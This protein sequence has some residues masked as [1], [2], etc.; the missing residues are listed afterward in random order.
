VNGT[1]TCAKPKKHKRNH[2]IVTPAPPQSDL[3]RWP[4]CKFDIRKPISFLFLLICTPLFGQRYV[5][6]LR[7]GMTKAQAETTLHRKLL[8]A[9]PNG[10][11]MTTFA[12]ERRF[13]GVKWKMLLDFNKGALNQV[14]LSWRPGES[15][16][17]DERSSPNSCVAGEIQAAYGKPI[18]VDRA[19]QLTSEATFRKNG[20]EV[21]LLDYSNIGIVVIYDRPSVSGL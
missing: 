14:T 9:E 8:P 15:G 20:T 21:T 11:G 3:K 5:D 12:T 7:Y 4:P 19:G 6:D 17:S 1:V 18:T 2:Q 16:E 13:C 10:P